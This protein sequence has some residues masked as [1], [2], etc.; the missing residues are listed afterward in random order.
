MQSSGIFCVN[1]M[2]NANLVCNV[3]DHSRTILRWFEDIPRIPV[4]VKTP[5]KRPTFSLLEKSILFFDL[6]PSLSIYYK[7]SF[8]SFRTIFWTPLYDLGPEEQYFI[9]QVNRDAFGRYE[10]KHSFNILEMPKAIV[11]KHSIKKLR[12]DQ[13]RCALQ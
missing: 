4:S 2:K 9:A 8:K 7:R 1:H 6:I 10:N 5:V 11:C 12:T 3:P 13:L